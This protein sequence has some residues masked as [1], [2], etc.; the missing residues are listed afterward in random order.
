MALILN[1]DFSMVFD[2]F[3]QG[4]LR[5]VGLVAQVLDVN[6]NSFDEVYSSGHG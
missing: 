3:V 4:D 5:E 2:D 1:T 6:G